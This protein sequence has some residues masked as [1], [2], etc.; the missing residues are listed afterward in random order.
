MKAPKYIGVAIFLLALGVRVA[1]G[2]FQL[3]QGFLAV[4]EGDYTLYQIGAEH[5]LTEGNFNN[6]L[7]LVRPPLFPLLVALLQ[8]NHTAIIIMNSLFG[9]LLA[10]LTMLLAF[11]LSLGQRVAW[12]A[13]LLVA[14]DPLTVRYTAFLGPEAI[15]FVGALGMLNALVALHNSK[16]QQQAFLWGITAAALLLLSAYTRPSI[17]LIWTGFSAWLLITRWRYAAAI[18]VFAALS[19]G[20]IA[21]WS[22]HNAAQFGNRTFSTVG[23]YTMTYYRAVS[24]LRLGEGLT[25]DEAYTEINRRIKADLGQDPSTATP[26][27]RHDY[28]AATP[29][30]AEALTQT[31]LDIFRTYPL[32]Y[33]ITLG[34]G[35]MRFFYLVPHFPPYENFTNPLSY[36]VPIWNVALLLLAVYGLWLAFRRRQ[37]TFLVI[38][39][40][41]GGYFTAG[42][43]LVKSAGLSG[44]ERTVMFPVIALAAAY[45]LTQVIPYFQSQ[46]N[47]HQSGNA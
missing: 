2:L 11:Q 46:P 30:I 8:D 41:F 43:L 4:S 16:N 44:R 10:P 19:Y 45:A 18:I 23:P 36:P 33:V 29:P 47:E 3:S 15:S 38:T 6:S 26:D 20:G 24:V 40:M 1:F 13:A 27:D 39:V 35:V 7:F 12:L 32:W 5:I 21:L 34:I 9:A 28:L 42:T 17:Y 22:A 31:S 25:P 37:W 14:L